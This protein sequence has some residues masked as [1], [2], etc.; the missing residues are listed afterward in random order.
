MRLT[1]FCSEKK[2]HLY[3]LVKF[4]LQILATISLDSSVGLYGLSS[5]STISAKLL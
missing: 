2:E 3:M 1:D 4:V 5:N